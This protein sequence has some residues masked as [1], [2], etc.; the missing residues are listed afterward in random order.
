MNLRG[1]M[2]IYCCHNSPIKLNHYQIEKL[3]ERIARRV[4]LAEICLMDAL[5]TQDLQ[6]VG[7]ICAVIHSPSPCQCIRFRLMCELFILIDLTTVVGFLN[8]AVIWLIN[9]LLYLI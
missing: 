4:T 3:E 8:M 1:L 2:E 9:S 6:T 7:R 5:F